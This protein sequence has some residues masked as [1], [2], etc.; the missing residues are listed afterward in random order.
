[1]NMDMFIIS[2]VGICPGL[3]KHGHIVDIILVFC[4]ASQLISMVT[5]TNSVFLSS[6]ICQNVLALKKKILSILTEVRRNH[7]VILIV[8]P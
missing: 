8:C 4:G 6:Y 7:K 1:M 5:S 3:V 2:V